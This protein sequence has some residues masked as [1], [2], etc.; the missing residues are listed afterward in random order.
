MWIQYCQIQK[1]NRQKSTFGAQ[2]C[3]GVLSGVYHRLAQNK[4]CVCAWLEVMS[5]IIGCDL[6]IMVMGGTCKRKSCRPYQRR[7]LWLWGA[8]RAVRGGG[9]APVTGI[10]HV[11]IC[12]GLKRRQSV[13][14]HRDAVQGLCKH[15]QQVG[16]I[17]FIYLLRRG[18]GGRQTEK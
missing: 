4:Q 7:L 6:G 14:I 3:R 8:W 12:Q 16:L 15:C 11:P 2:P 18:K 5:G 17:F 10:G 13:L 9:T 1:S